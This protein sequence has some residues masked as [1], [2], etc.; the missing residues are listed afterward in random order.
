MCWNGSL[1]LTIPSKFTLPNI[2]EG[3]FSVLS[4]TGTPIA[5]GS[6]TIEATPST[7]GFVRMDTQLLIAAIMISFI[8]IVIIVATIGYKN[9][10]R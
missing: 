5:V 6:R 10:K 4:L 9:K 3:T 1:W 7:I 2:M 8:S